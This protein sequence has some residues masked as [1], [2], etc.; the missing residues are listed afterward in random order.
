VTSKASNPKVTGFFALNSIS[1]VDFEVLSTLSFG[2]DSDELTGS[3]QAW[4][5]LLSGSQEIEQGHS[6]KIGIRLA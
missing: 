3:W 6:S 5:L 4:R 1:C 2:G